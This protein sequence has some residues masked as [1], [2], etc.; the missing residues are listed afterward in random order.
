MLNLNYK[1]IDMERAIN[2]VSI[3]ISAKNDNG[4]RR[5]ALWQQFDF[6]WPKGLNIISQNNS[7]INNCLQVI[8]YLDCRDRQ[9][10][11]IINII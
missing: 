5:S 11:G 3:E 4:E 7:I 2:R 8:L 10:R 1:Y 9:E 6:N